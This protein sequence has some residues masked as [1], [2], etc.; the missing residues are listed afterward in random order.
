MPASPTGQQVDWSDNRRFLGPIGYITPAEAE[1]AFYANLNT[2]DMV[3]Q[4]SS[5]SPSGKPGAVQTGW[6]FPSCLRHSPVSGPSY[7]SCGLDS[8]AILEPG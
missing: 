6:R 3:A 5:K 7:S 4:W 1:K 2:L 8:M